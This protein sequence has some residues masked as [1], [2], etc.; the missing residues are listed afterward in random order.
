MA[1]LAAEKAARAPLNNQTFV[2]GNVNDSKPV[3]DNS[4][5]ETALSVGGL[6][7]KVLV[8]QGTACKVKWYKNGAPVT[9]YYAKNFV[10]ADALTFI[11]AML[12]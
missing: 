9:S 10:Q 6:T 4:A 12:A 5:L 7:A 2:G 8:R 11:N 3:A 1:T